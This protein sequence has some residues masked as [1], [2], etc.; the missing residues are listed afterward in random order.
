MNYTSRSMRRRRGTDKWE[1]ALS[2]K[3]PLTDIIVTTYH[4]IEA[5][6][7]AQ[8]RKKRAA[9]TR[10]QDAFDIEESDMFR[11]PQAAPEPQYTVAQLE[12]MLAEARKRE[13][14]EGVA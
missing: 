11:L 7:E 4:T 14:L 3:D 12:A 10:I 9:V 5:K 2:H 6:T 13:G 8:A 1:I